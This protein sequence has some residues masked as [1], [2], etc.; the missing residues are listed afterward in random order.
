ML[1]KREGEISTGKLPGIY[2]DK[3]RFILLVNPPADIDSNTDKNHHLFFA[4]FSRTGILAG[5]NLHRI[6]LECCEAWVDVLG[7]LRTQ[8]KHTHLLI[9]LAY[10]STNF[11]LVDLGL[12]LR[13]LT[14][15]QFLFL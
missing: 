4:E 6:D 3:V 9:N 15:D 12:K 7:F 14:Q 2:F 5:Y 11:I 10:V 1:K 13:E 8:D